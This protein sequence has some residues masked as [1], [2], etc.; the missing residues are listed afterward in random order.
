MT[1]TTTDKQLYKKNN[2]I[3]DSNTKSNIKILMKVHFK[4]GNSAR[5]K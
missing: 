1:R 5:Y 3:T 4:S 2:K